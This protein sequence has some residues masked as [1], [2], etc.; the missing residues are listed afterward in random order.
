MAVPKKRKSKSRRERRRANHDKVAPKNITHC[1][2]CAAPRMS[3]RVCGTCG[4][5][6]DRTVIEFVDPAAKT[7][8]L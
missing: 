8:A 7:E 1:P 6:R 5:Y 3:H 4:F 2:K